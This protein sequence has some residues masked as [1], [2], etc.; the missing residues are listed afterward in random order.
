MIFPQYLCIILVDKKFNLMLN[1]EGK[2][3]LE[4]FLNSN[5]EINL[6]KRFAFLG[7][8]ESFDNKLAYLTR[9]AEPENW[10]PKDGETTTPVIFYYIVHTFERLFEQDKVI[11]NE[12][13]SVA[14]ANTG[15]MTPQGDE[16]LFYFEKA[17]SH[18]PSKPISCYWYLKAFLV[19]N[20]NTIVRLGMPKPEK[21]GRASCRER[22]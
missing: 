18:D 6:L 15:L 4:R 7:S 1:V 19:E 20:D 9:I 8:R 5:S 12:S 10:Y 16:I 3:G 22:V 13:E 17:P 2:M 21:I 11:V 14:L